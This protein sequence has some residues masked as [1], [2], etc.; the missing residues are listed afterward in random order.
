MTSPNLKLFIDG[1]DAA[2]IH[3]ALALRPLTA[4]KTKNTYWAMSPKASRYGMKVDAT[5]LPNGVNTVLSVGSSV[6]SAQPIALKSKP[7]DSSFVKGR[8]PVEVAGVKHVIDSGIHD[9]GDGTFTLM[10]SV[11]R[12]GGGNK[13][14]TAL[15]AASK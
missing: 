6:K 12:S 14:Q 7:G 5:I 1:R 2:E 9:F 3:E 10:T 8:V 15:S 4:T 13:P 11:H